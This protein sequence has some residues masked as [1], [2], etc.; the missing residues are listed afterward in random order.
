MNKKESEEIILRR[1]SQSDYIT[2][3]SLEAGKAQLYFT[4]GTGCLLPVLILCMNLFSVYL[5]SYHKNR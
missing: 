2:R 4:K 1:N 5:Y 3:T